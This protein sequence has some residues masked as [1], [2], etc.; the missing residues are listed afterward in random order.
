MQRALC[1]VMSRV[2]ERGPTELRANS[3]KR[4][5]VPWWVVLKDGL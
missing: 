2:M 1:H 5:G 3:R 4:T